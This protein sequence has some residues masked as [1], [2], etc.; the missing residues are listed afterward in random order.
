MEIKYSDV[1]ITQN[2]STCGF[3]VRGQV[4]MLAKDWG[5]WPG[6]SHWYLA[7]EQSIHQGFFSI[8][9]PVLEVF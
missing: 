4:Y 1:F 5:S 6:S 7:K 8:L 3:A 9:N 2:V